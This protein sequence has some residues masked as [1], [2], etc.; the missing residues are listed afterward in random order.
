MKTADQHIQ[1]LFQVGQPFNL[2]G[3][4][5]SM[6]RHGLT[7]GK[8]SMYDFQKSGRM[9]ISGYICYLERKE[10]LPSFRNLMKSLP[11]GKCYQNSMSDHH[12]IFNRCFGGRR[13]HCCRV[14]WK[15]QSRVSWFPGS[16]WPFF[17]KKRLVVKVLSSSK[18]SYMFFWWWLTSRDSYVI[19]VYIYSSNS[20]FCARNGYILTNEKSTKVYR[21]PHATVKSEREKRTK[22]GSHTGMSCWYL[23]NGLFHPKRSK[24]FTFHK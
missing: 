7:S 10:R 8:I 4:I 9:Y 11:T 6:V 19:A 16:P 1:P 3:A 15:I 18:R 22:I 20:P 12:G 24:L 21:F 13:H 17:L 5:T 14:A 2:W 23:A